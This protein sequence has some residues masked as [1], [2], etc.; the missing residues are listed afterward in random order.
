ME[1]PYCN[2]PDCRATGEPDEDGQ[3]EYR[4]PAC[5]EYFVAAEE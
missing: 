2:C 5:G 1:C 4:C 3:V